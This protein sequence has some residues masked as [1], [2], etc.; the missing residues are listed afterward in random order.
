MRLVKAEVRVEPS[1]APYFGLRILACII[2]G[3]AIGSWGNA[4]GGMQVEFEKAI[5]EVRA[6]IVAAAEKKKL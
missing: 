4:P 5:D 6:T 1:L 3:D 2:E